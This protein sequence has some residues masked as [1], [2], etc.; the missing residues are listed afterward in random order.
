MN[1]ALD[2]TFGRLYQNCIRQFRNR[3]YLE[4]KCSSEP[5]IHSLWKIT[6]YPRGDSMIFK[7]S[8]AADPSRSGTVWFRSGMV[9]SCHI[10]YQKFGEFMFGKIITKKLIFT[11]NFSSVLFRHRRTRQ[12]WLVI[13]RLR[14]TFYWNHVVTHRQ[15]WAARK[16]RSHFISPDILWSKSSIDELLDFKRRYLTTGFNKINRRWLTKWHKDA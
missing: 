16:L 8:W 3:T 13:L 14:T 6:G 9:P 4:P 7:I 10:N 2:H 11:S 1:T 5:L 12:T 15:E